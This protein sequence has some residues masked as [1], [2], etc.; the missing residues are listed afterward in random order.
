MLLDYALTTVA[1]L[2]SFLGITNNTNDGLLETLINVSTNFIEGQANRRFKE[3][4]YTAELMNGEGTDLLVLKAFPI[5]KAVAFK[6][7][8][9]ADNSSW[10]TL[11]A[12]TYRID[13]N[14]GYVK[15]LGGKFWKST[16]NYRVTYTGGAESIETTYPDLEY[17]CWKLCKDAFDRRKGTAG[18]KRQSLGS[19]SVEFTSSY[20]ENPEVREIVDQYKVYSV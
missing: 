6:I 9:S 10:E 20:F 15:M 8:Y 1:R 11:D 19:Y 13:Y 5:K 14:A 7:E 3:T 12:D 16:G 2:K 18:I 4:T 17:A